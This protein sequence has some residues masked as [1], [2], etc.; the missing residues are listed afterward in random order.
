VLLTSHSGID[1]SSFSQG[2]RAIGYSP[3]VYPHIDIFFLL[4]VTA[5]VLTTG[6]VA[7]IFPAIRALKLK[8]VEA[9]RQD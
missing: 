3:V 6:L 9:L 7:S 2:L 8:P 4:L 5:L 1:L